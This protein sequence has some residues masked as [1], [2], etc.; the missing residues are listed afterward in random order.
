MSLHFYLI[1]LILSELIFI[2]DIFLYSFFCN[3]TITINIKIFINV[4]REHLLL[5]RFIIFGEILQRNPFIL[6]SLADL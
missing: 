2:Y 4:I 5:A 6:L 3:I 1:I